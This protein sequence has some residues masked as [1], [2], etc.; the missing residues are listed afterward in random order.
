MHYLMT[1]GVWQVFMFTIRDHRITYLMGSLS[2][3]R[4]TSLSRVSSRIFQ[5]GGGGEAQHQCHCADTHVTRGG[6]GELCQYWL[7][8]T[9]ANASDLIGQWGAGAFQPCTAHQLYMYYRKWGSM[10]E[11]L[12]FVTYFRDGSRIFHSIDLRCALGTLHSQIILNFSNQFPA[13]W[14]ELKDFYLT[15]ILLMLLLSMAMK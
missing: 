6:G 3:D 5:L 4:V 8:W 1:A 15:L 13:F 10:S 14:W 11:I 9:S 2:S 12:G 7:D